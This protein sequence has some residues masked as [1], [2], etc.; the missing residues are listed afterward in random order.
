MS[1]PKKS[2]IIPWHPLFLLIVSMVSIT[3]SLFAF[4]NVWS[5]NEKYKNINQNMRIIQSD[6]QSAKNSYSLF[7]LN[8]DT[9]EQGKYTEYIQYLD[10]RTD[11]A[12]VRMITIVGVLFSIISLFSI[13]LAFKAPN[14][15][16]K[17]IK[18]LDTKLKLASEVSESTNY[19]V[20]MV[21]AYSED[22][23]YG[24]LR[25]INDVI[26][27]EPKRPDGYLARG[28]LYFREHEY[29]KAINDYMQALSLGGEIQRCHSALGIS[30]NE[31]GQFER[32]LSHFSKA[33]NIS[34]N[35]RDYCNRGICYADNREYD[36]AISDYSKALAFDPDSCE[37]LFNRGKAYSML[38]ESLK[39]TN[40]DDKRRYY[41]AAIHDL[42]SIQSTQ[43]STDFIN[44]HF[45]KENKKITKLEELIALTYLKFSTFEWKQQNEQTSFEQLFKAA[46]YSMAVDGSAVTDSIYKVITDRIT[47]ASI[48]L[49][50]NSISSKA[51]KGYGIRNSNEAITAYISNDFRS[52]EGIFTVLAKLGCDEGYINLAYMKRRGECRV[53]HDNVFTLL[54]KVREQNSAICCINKALCLLTGIDCYQDTE[55]AIRVLSMSDNDFCEALEWWSDENIVGRKESNIVLY[56]IK[57]NQLYPFVDDVSLENRRAMA[58][59]DGYL[60][61]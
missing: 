41:E 48:K 61:A 35:A 20:A 16:D 37:V 8:K 6:L 29:Q 14:D 19:K 59:A 3:F 52:A 27:Q 40:V 31:L 26:T 13:L 23:T 47:Q 15:I 10:S 9:D 28:G 7:S 43:I 21:A 11:N 45:R 46:E 53:T 1:T 18:I 30:Y 36:K 24:R 32:A 17:Q 49:K 39:E 44:D 5:L 60:V 42:T 34:E 12:I 2:R 50:T 51:L 25:K 54:N 55:K 33:L 57:Q 56:L 38:A 22:S 4:S 58:L